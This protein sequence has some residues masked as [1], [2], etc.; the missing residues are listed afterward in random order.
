MAQ[1][2]SE[3]DELVQGR[4]YAML[5]ATHAM[6]GN[7]LGLWRAQPTRALGAQ[8]QATNHYRLTAGIG[9]QR[10]YVMNFDSIMF[11]TRLVSS[12]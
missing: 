11:K 3:G 5:L 9:P 12:V 6:H 2:V 1:H 7:Q 4:Q 8:P 10:L